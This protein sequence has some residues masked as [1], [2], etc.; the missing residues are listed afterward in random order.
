MRLEPHSI[1]GDLTEEFNLHLMQQ[2]L[3]RRRS[4]GLTQT[5]DLSFLSKLT[6]NLEASLHKMTGQDGVSQND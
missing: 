4:L 2:K 5:S 6:Q 1:G 3:S